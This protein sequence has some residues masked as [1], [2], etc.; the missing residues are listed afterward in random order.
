MKNGV[1]FSKIVWKDYPE[2]LK[3]QH[4]NCRILNKK[5]FKLRYLVDD[6]RLSCKMV[7]LNPSE[8]IF[9]SVSFEKNGLGK[10]EVIVRK[11]LV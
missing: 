5:P 2:N 11:K 3:L 6:I 10:I 7:S 9:S 1:N 4:Q 8:F